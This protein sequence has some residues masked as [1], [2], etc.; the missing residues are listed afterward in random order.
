MIQDSRFMNL[1]ELQKKCKDFYNKKLHGNQ[2][3]IVKKQMERFGLV[4]S[5]GFIALV[6]LIAF[7]DSDFSQSVAA[8]IAVVLAAAGIYLLARGDDGNF[9]LVED[10]KRSLMA[11]ATQVRVLYDKLDELKTNNKTLPP[12]EF[13]EYF[14]AQ[15]EA[16]LS[17][18][19]ETLAC[20][21]AI[22]VQQKSKQGSPAQPNIYDAFLVLERNFSVMCSESELFKEKGNSGPAARDRLRESALQTLEAI[23]DL[24]TESLQEAYQNM[25]ESSDFFA[26]IRDDLKSIKRQANPD[27]PPADAGAETQTTSTAAT[28]KPATTSGIDQTEAQTPV[29]CQENSSS[30]LAVPQ[31]AKINVPS[32][33]SKTEGDFEALGFGELATLISLYRKPTDVDFVRLYQAAPYVLQQLQNTADFSLEEV[34]AM[35]RAE[36]IS[37]APQDEENSPRA[38]EIIE[39]FSLA[40][41]A[42]D[43]TPSPV[44]GTLWALMLFGRE[45]QVLNGSAREEKI[46][47]ELEAI[48]AR[49]HYDRMLP[50]KESDAPADIRSV[51]LDQQLQEREEQ[52]RER[53][54]TQDTLKTIYYSIGQYV[55]SLEDHV[56]YALTRE[57]IEKSLV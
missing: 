10:Q 53:H 6:V 22:K 21:Y 9:A 51:P 5:V 2:M 31:L 37:L 24:T 7:I 46:Q 15:R 32:F 25:Q 12:A 54:A 1:A 11:I 40:V 48:R 57:E 19:R 45:A 16:L 18:D 39:Q 50:R 20:M 28:S 56:G 4:G 41:E 27:T 38:I 34:S 13:R 35:L 23:T 44:V 55:D 29:D 26:L 14:H 36:F 3:L 33:L 17:Y 30:S 49:D 42:L 43:K 52:W 47:H 8:A